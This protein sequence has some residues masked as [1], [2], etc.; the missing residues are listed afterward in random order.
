MTRTRSA[1]S[2]SAWGALPTAVSRF[3]SRRA[4]DGG[5]AVEDARSARKVA[6]RLVD[7]R[8]GFS[9]GRRGVDQV[10]V[11]GVLKEESRIVDDGELL[12]LILRN[13]AYQRPDLGD[14]RQSA[15]FFGQ[16]GGVSQVAPEEIDRIGARVGI[17]HQIEKG[18]DQFGI[19]G[20]QIERVEVEAQAGEQRQAKNDGRQGHADHPIAPPVEKAVERRERGPTDRRRLAGRREH[21][22]QRRK[23]A[24]GRQERDDHAGSGDQAEF[25]ET[26]IRGRQERVESGRDRG[27]RKQKRARYAA[28]RGLKSLAEIAVRIPLGAVADA[29]LDAE[30]DAKA[31]EKHGEG[32]GDEVQRSDHPDPDG[33]GEA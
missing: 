33:G 25:G 3:A 12:V 4:C 15:Q 7:R 10:Q 18:R 14:F 1:S 26:H 9:R 20:S 24:N 5:R 27:R 11:E 8:Q 32:D 2:L 16:G 21:A 28:R 29:E 6:G 17:A 22:E 23:Q 19:L 31:D 13:E 30:I